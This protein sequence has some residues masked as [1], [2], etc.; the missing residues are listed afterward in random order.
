MTHYFLAQILLNPWAGRNI[1]V[2]QMSFRNHY[3]TPRFQPA[4][5]VCLPQSKHKRCRGREVYLFVVEVKHPLGS[6]LRPWSLIIPAL[7]G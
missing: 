4:R 5:H 2:L 7:H 1:S 3:M 6:E